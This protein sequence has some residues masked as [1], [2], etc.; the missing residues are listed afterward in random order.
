MSY[1]LICNKIYVENRGWRMITIVL[2]IFSLL[3]YPQV[4]ELCYLLTSCQMPNEQRPSL[5]QRLVETR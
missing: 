3:F 5:D 1:M 4:F 2:F